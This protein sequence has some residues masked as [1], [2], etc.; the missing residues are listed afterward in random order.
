MRS[1]SRVFKSLP[2]LP[3]FGRS[4]QEQKSQYSSRRSLG[5]TPVVLGM[6]VL[7]LGR[8]H[9]LQLQISYLRLGDEADLI[10]I[11]I[12]LLFR[13]AT[14]SSLVNKVSLIFP[15]SECV[16]NSSTDAFNKARPI[17]IIGT[18]QTVW[19]DIPN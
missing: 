8:Y 18:K 12:A 1:Q 17:A 6:W 5:R 4:Q 7:H 15:V 10:V 19:Q 13:S 3:E 9:G 16:E 11:A 2:R 14:F